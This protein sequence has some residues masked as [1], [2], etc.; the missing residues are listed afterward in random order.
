MRV[1]E[2]KFEC[3]EPWYKALT[4]PHL[5]VDYID[6]VDCLNLQSLYSLESGTHVNLNSLWIPAIAIDVI[7]GDFSSWGE[8]EE[9]SSSSIGSRGYC[10]QAVYI[11]KHIINTTQNCM[12]QYPYPSGNTSN[13]G[14]I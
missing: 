11:Q 1:W 4:L 2:P 12:F 8:F 10:L 6:G 5:P 13:G 14:T 7:K 3:N 9:L